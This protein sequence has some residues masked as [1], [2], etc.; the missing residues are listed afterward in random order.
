MRARAFA[1]MPFAL[2]LSGAT[3]RAADS[4]ACADAA[5]RAQVLRDQQ[6]LVAARQLL[7]SCSRDSCPAVVRRDCIDWLG[8]VEARL[9]RIVPIARD[10]SGA[11]LTEVRVSVDDATLADRI[12]GRSLAVDPGE[13][14]VRFERGAAATSVRIVAHESENRLVE[15][16]FPE[17]VPR[18][19]AERAR[20]LPAATLVFGAVAL[21]SF[22]GYA[23]FGLNTRA[24][25]DRMRDACA[26]RC[27][28]SDVDSARRELVLT[29]VAFA[30]GT[31]A[32]AATLVSYFFRPKTL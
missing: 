32:A 10:A 27:A 11:D 15:A 21:V 28:S 3:A 8:E 25:V 6:K 22:G 9:P 23:Y 30:L 17:A 29:N 20:P 19:T 16:R 31:I 5:E 26:P 2:L 13:H 24:D 1:L 12:D 14:V 18:E 7:V 4:E